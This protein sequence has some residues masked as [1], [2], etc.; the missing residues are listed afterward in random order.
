[1]FHQI[2]KVEKLIDFLSFACRLTK[3]QCLYANARND[4]LLPRISVHCTAQVHVAL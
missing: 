3:S 2:Y 4:F 1:M